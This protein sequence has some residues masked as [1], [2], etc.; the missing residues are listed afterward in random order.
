MGDV[1]CFS[2]EK[3]AGVKDGSGSKS[4]EGLTLFPQNSAT[5]IAESYNCKADFAIS[6]GRLQSDKEQS[7]EKLGD[8][9]YVPHKNYGCSGKKS[10]FCRLCH[11]QVT[12]P[13]N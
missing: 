9:L 5:V 12:R 10:I 6:S 7:G 13:T 1:T 3:V 4:K 11:P 2:S 8:G